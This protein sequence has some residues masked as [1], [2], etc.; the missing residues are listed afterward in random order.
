MLKKF[1][2]IF[3]TVK[4]ADEPEFRREITSEAEFDSLAATPPN[5][6]FSGTRTVKCVVD[7]RSLHG[8]LGAEPRVYFVHSVLYPFHFKFCKAHLLSA[9]ERADPYAHHKFNARHYT[10]ETRDYV[11]LTISH[12]DFVGKFVVEP[13]PADTLTPTRMRDCL[14]LVASKFKLGALTFRPMSEHQELHVKPVVAAA[15]MA[16]INAAQLFGKL[17]FQSVCNGSSVG[18]VRFVNATDAAALQ[19]IRVFEIIVVSDNILDLPLCAGLITTFPQTPLSHTALLCQNR[20]TPSFYLALGCEQAADLNAKDRARI[21]LVRSLDGQWVQLTVRPQDFAMTAIPKAEA[22]KLLQARAAEAKASLPV[23]SLTP[24]FSR[25][26][27]FHIDPTTPLPANLSNAIGAKAFGL[28]R[29]A[30]VLAQFAKSVPVSPIEG[31]VL[32]FAFYEQ[33]MREI[34]ATEIA[35]AT[36]TA[37]KAEAAR[38]SQTR[39]EFYASENPLLYESALDAGD[40][41]DDDD[42]AAAFEFEAA[43]SN[44]LT[45]SF[46]L[47]ASGAI[48]TPLRLHSE[49]LCGKLERAILV[50]PTDLPSLSAACDAL[51]PQLNAWRGAPVILRSST[52]VEDLKGFNGAGLYASVSCK[53]PLDRAKLAGAIVRCYA[54]MWTRRCVIER[55]AFGVSEDAVAM[56]LL[57][58]PYATNIA[59]N[60]VALSTIPFRPDFPGTYINVQHADFK[61]TDGDGTAEVQAVYDEGDGTVEIVSRS[62][63][64]DGAPVLREQDA[65]HIHAAVKAL[66]A[67]MSADGAVDV[68]FIVQEAPETNERT[69]LVL[70]CRPC[71]FHL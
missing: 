30:H 23:V 47:D 1:R 46:Q 48:T 50:A 22:I 26:E 38:L 65:K 15:G 39:D 61:V 42:D 10:T 40:D 5:A 71:V 54:S 25:R 8:E 16:T 67:R 33:F 2:S 36:L 35:H 20:G 29:A 21:E 11:L 52:N 53:Q 19:R 57:V 32:P 7:L 24:D 13:W 18:R 44:P 62:S 14:E 6:A 28:A 70:Q 49:V 66:Q 60:G 4:T 17:R 12:Y 27:L 31:V 43:R 68:E 56:A 59:A 64:N 58:Q 37:L 45:Q 51:A 63:L 34:G 3:G 69:L 55:F 41:G 9:Q